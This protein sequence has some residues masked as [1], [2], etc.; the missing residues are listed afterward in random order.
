MV[1]GVPVDDALVVEV[2]EADDDLGAVELD[3]LGRE[4]LLLLEVEE[5]LAAVHIVHHK[6]ELIC[7][8]RVVC[9]VRV[10]S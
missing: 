9:A 6:V 2:L 7:A 4:G 8:C 10:V 3:A 5:Q 1:E